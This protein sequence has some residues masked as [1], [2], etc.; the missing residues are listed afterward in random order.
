M[1]SFKNGKYK[2]IRTKDHFQFTSQAFK[3]VNFAHT[4]VNTERKSTQR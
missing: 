2:K 3:I 1:V 4:G